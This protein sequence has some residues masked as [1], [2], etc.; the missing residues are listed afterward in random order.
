MARL[1]P[2]PKAITEAITDPVCG[3]KVE[4]GMTRLVSNYQGHSY[5]FCSEDCRRA[6]EKNPEK[7]LNPKTIKHKWPTGWWGRYLERMAKANKELFGG[8]P[9]RCH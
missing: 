1:A 9:P 2:T 7:Y 8:G 5:W 4:P 3:M 6:F